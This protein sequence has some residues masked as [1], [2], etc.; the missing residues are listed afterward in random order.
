[1]FQSSI[2]QEIEMHRNSAQAEQQVAITPTTLAIHS[3]GRER[4]FVLIIMAATAIALCAVLGMA[5]DIGRVFIAK[6]ET[7][8]YCD[9]AALAAALALDGT[10]T[11]ISSAQTAVTNSA[12]TWNLDST[13]VSNPTVT[14]AQTTTGPWSA[15]PNPATGYIYVRVS[16]TVPM[17][18]YFIPVVAGLTTQNVASS[19][20]AGQISITSFPQGLAPYSAIG[21]NTTAPSFGL[22]PGNSYDIRWPNVSKGASC[23]PTNPNKIDNCFLS[24]P[25]SGDSFT[26]KQEVINY[27]GTQTA[28][29]WGSTSNNTI[30]QEILDVIQVE[31]VSVGTNIQPV[32]TSGNKQSEAGYLDV[33]ASEDISTDYVTNNDSTT[34]SDYFSSAHNGRRLL[35]VPVIMPSTT[36]NTTVVGYGS[37]LLYANGATS[38]YYKKN[39]GGNTPYCAIY[40]G[41]YQVGGTGTG[42]GGTTGATFVKLVQ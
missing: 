31:P 16:A 15:S 2:S 9:S 14:F 33:R 29:Y 20:T 39:S 30:A 3:S 5:V 32:L 12:N 13:K 28:G 38:D 34:L 10:T 40:A 41:P 23:D 11:G 19:A 27:W 17:N 35:P 1:M 25:C 37:F 36:T 24:S 42:T 18:L 22:V 6:N 21:I 26:A 8:A 4:G 7:Q